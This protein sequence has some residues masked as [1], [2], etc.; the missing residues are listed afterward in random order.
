VRANTDPFGNSL[1]FRDEDFTVAECVAGVAKERG[2]TGS[3]VALAWILN[4]PYITSPIIG[5]TKMDHL[6]Q[7]IAALEIKLSDDEL[8]KLE[9]SYRPHPV[10][11]H[12]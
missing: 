9:E 4:K 7:A 3:Q 6:D 2:V 8:K 1:Y 5:A 12:S 11:G 10:L